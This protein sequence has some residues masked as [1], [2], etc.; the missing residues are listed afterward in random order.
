MKPL[1]APHGAKGVL[2]HIGLC[3]VDLDAT[4][5]RVKEMGLARILTEITNWFDGYIFKGIMGQNLKLSLA[6][7]I[8]PTSFVCDVLEA[9]CISHKGHLM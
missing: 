6:T 5:A 8:N 9:R 4:E 3:V 1:N 7:R 2:N